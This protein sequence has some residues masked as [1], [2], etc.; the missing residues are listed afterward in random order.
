MSSE[1]KDLDL[2]KDNETGLFVQGELQG[3]DFTPSWVNDQGVRFQASLKLTF[4]VREKIT[5]NV[6]GIPVSTN[7]MIPLQIALNFDDKD[8]PEQVAKYNG[9]IG[10]KLKLRLVPA[11]NATFKLSG[12]NIL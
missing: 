1:K 12:E 10:K 11:K 7:A 9:M 3:V 5:K 8:I 2:T 6:G 4:L